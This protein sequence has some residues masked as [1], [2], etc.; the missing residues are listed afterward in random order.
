MDGQEA[1]KD[2]AIGFP[3]GVTKVDAAWLKVTEAGEITKA[4]FV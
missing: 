4:F 2:G 1:V 3:Q